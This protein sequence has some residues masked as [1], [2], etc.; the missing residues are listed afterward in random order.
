MR[1][2]ELDESSPA[3]KKPNRN[4]EY[5]PRWLEMATSCSAPPGMAGLH[6]LALLRQAFQV[7][8]FLSSGGF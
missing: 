4:I 1:T 7:I 5:T 3:A 6:L 2:F 8:P